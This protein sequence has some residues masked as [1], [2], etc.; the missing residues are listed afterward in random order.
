MSGETDHSAQEMRLLRRTPWYSALGGLIG[1]IIGALIMWL[2][3]HC[4]CPIAK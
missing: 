3:F 4:G 1:A 2:L